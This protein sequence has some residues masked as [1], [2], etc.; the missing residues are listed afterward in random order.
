MYEIIIGVLNF[1]WTS[2]KDLFPSIVVL[3]G[4]ILTIRND[5]RSW[6]RTKYY[7]FRM[8]KLVEFLTLFNQVHLKLLNRIWHEGNTDI[9]PF[10]SQLAELEEAHMI[11]ASMFFDDG[12]VVMN[13]YLITAVEVF[14]TKNIEQARQKLIHAKVKAD[15]KFKRWLLKKN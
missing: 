15:E 7:D 10:R 11:V 2:I 8:I 9:L 5:R 6:I 1:L 3:V 14:T 13:E 12:P 4:V